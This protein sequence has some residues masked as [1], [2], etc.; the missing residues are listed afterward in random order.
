MK[1][2]DDAELQRVKA[3]SRLKFVRNMHLKLCVGCLLSSMSLMQCL[4]TCSLSAASPFA[5]LDVMT[6]L[7]Q[8]KQIRSLSLLDCAIPVPALATLLK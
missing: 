1:I 2:W 8:Y 6:A 5:D 7:G 3:F 4:P